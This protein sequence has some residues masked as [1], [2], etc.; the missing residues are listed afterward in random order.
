MRHKGH[1]RNMLFLFRLKLAPD[2]LNCQ[3]LSSVCYRVL[4]LII[5]YLLDKSDVQQQVAAL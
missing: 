1:T 2:I 4:L 5:L 3:I